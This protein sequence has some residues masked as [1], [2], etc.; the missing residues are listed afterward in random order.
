VSTKIISHKPATVMRTATQQVRD[1]S[2]AMERLRDQ[3]FSGIKRLEAQYFDGVKKVTA[4]LHLVLEEPPVPEPAPEAA[5]A[6][7]ETV[8]RPAPPPAPAPKRPPAH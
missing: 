5:D 3:F 1:H 7:F 4:S 6:E 2:A 8:E